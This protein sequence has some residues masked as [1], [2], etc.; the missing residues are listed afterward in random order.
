MLDPNGRVALISGAS[1]GIGRALAQALHDAGYCVSLGLR[2][3][4]NAAPG[5]AGLDPARLHLGTYVA[6]DW[7]GHARWVEAAVARFGR[8]DVLVNN[9]GIASKATIRTATEADLDAIWAVN[10]KAPLRMIQLCLPYLEASGTGRIVN[11]AS[12]SGVR[13]R[14]DH[15]A[16]NMSKFAVM[17]LT[18][19]A[20]RLGW[21]KGVRDGGVPL[22]HADGHDG[23]H[24]PDRSGG[25]DGPRRSGGAGGCRHRA[26]EHSLGRGADRELPA[27]GPRM[28]GSRRHL[29]AL[30]GGW[31]MIRIAT[32][33]RGHRGTETE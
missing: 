24:G 3:P 20:R 21:E 7:E 5:L 17:A 16:Y 4:R 15:V 29:P 8:I 14:N 27:G 31:K 18:H 10:C 25:D 2:D 11:V 12:L 1:R 26:A 32:S 9:A 28:T 6:E 22:L 30:G 19:G 23:G 33:R 13:V